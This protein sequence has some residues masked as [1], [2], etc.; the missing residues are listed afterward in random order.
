MIN[1]HHDRHGGFRDNLKNK[2][3]KNLVIVEQI[4]SKSAAEVKN[5][6]VSQLKR[7]G[8]NVVANEQVARNFFLSEFG[9]EMSSKTAQDFQLDGEINADWQ[10]TIYVTIREFSCSGNTDDYL[11][12]VDVV[13]D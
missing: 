13:E 6:V 11:Y 5:E 1:K 2:K 8:Y 10:T 12:M 3:M 4:S 7:F 9:K